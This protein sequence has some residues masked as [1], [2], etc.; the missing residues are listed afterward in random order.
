MSSVAFLFAVAGGHFF[1][2]RCSVIFVAFVAP[3]AFC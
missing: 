2:A 3:A 1:G